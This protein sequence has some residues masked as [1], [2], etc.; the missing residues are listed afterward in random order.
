MRLKIGV[1]LKKDEAESYTISVDDEEA[2]NKLLDEKF[3][4]WDW[5]WGYSPKYSFTNKVEIDGRTLEIYLEVKKGRI[6]NA[7]LEGNYFVEPYTTE[8]SALLHGKQHFYEDIRDI[9]KTDNE[10][11]IYAFF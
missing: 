4:T 2:I 7:N 5:R 3:T 8:L 9:L 10:E 11:L 1:Q 6:E